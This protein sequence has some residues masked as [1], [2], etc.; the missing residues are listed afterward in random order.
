MI[1]TQFVVQL[2]PAVFFCDRRMSAPHKRRQSIEEYIATRIAP[3]S[4]TRFILT[5]STTLDVTYNTRWNPKGD[6]EITYVF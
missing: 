1:N 5:Q 6:S 4:P 2:Q 3:Q